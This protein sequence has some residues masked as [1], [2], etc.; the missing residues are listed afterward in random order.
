M[1]L[2]SSNAHV[3]PQADNIT[4]CPLSIIFEES[5]GRGLLEGSSALAVIQQ[6][7]MVVGVG[8]ILSLK[9][10]LLAGIARI[11]HCNTK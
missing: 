5:K 3:L 8:V 1:H 10:Q 2:C 11:W 9:L 7:L 4:D 6:W